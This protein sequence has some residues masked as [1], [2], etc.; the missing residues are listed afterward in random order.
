M[1]LSHNN[2]NTEPNSGM[3]THFNQQFSLLPA[4]KPELQHSLG[5]VFHGPGLM[6]GDQEQDTAT[7]QAMQEQPIQHITPRRRRGGWGS[8]QPVPGHPPG[9]GT[10]IADH[11]TPAGVAVGATQATQVS[12]QVAYAYL[13]IRVPCQH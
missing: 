4:S 9:D 2:E 5:S 8:P 13:P 10:Q 11:F 1:P 3:L 7:Q 6:A 12:P